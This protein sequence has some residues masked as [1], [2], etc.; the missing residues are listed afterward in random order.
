MEKPKLHLAQ[1]NNWQR[2][3]TVCKQKP[4]QTNKN[5]NWQ[6][7]STVGKIKITG[8]KQL[9]KENKNCSKT[10]NY[11]WK[12]G[13]KSNIAAGKNNNWQTKIAVVKQKLH[14][15]NKNYS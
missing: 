1:N 8:R 5:Y 9:Q 7:K 12:T 10:Q 14:L 11:S 6:T 13:D 2:N 4:Q 15:V 3:I